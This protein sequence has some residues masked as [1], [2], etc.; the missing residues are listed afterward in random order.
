MP[1]MGATTTAFGKAR[2]RWTDVVTPRPSAA[3][4]ALSAVSRAAPS[5]KTLA[6]IRE[7]AEEASPA[8]R[9]RCRP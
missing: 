7:T 5:R 4:L 3:N 9:Q 1:M 8:F 6:D 2:R